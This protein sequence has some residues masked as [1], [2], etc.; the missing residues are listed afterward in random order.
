MGSV[1]RGRWR[2]G[3]WGALSPNSGM[4]SWAWLLAAV[5]L[6]LLTVSVARPPLTATK[7]EATLEPEEASN[8]YQISKPTVCSVHPGEVLKLSCPLPG[9]G[10]ITW[11]KDGSSLGNNNRTLIEQ[12]VLQI[13]DTT[14]KDSGLYA[15]TSVGKDTVCFIVNV[16]D[17]ISSGDDEDDTE[18]SEDTGADG[19][20]LSAPYWTSSA[21]MEKKL[22]AVPAANTVKFRCAAG[23]NP[24]PKLRWLKNSK[25]FRQEDRMGGYKVRSQHWTLIMESVVPSDK[26][27]YTCLVE[28]EFGSINH[29]YTL[30]VVERS[31]HRPIL[32][33]GL[34]A[35]TTVHVGEDA[36]FVCKVYSDAQP[37]IQWLKHITQNGSRY[38]IDGH[39]YVRVLKT[40]G[41]NTTDKE[42]EV[43]YLPNVTFE[44]A[45]EYTC[46]AGNSIGISYHTAWLTVLPALEK[47]PE[48]ISPDYVEIAIYCAGVFLIACMVGIVVVCRMRNTAKK[49][50][51]GG[52]PAVHKLTKQI[53]LRR[54]VTVSADSS[55]SMN[56]STPLVRI[57]TRRSSAHDEPIPEYDL[58]ED[59]RWEFS[60]DRLT[61]GKPL[62]EGC[63]GQVVMA[64]ALGIDKDKPKEAVTV[65]VKMLKDDA[66]EKDL[67]DLVSEMEMMKMIG[68]H[69]NII[70]LLGACTQ[71]GPLYVIVEYASK[72]NLREYLRARRPP[73]MEYSY[74]IARVSDEQLTFKDLVSCTYQVARGMEY[75]ASQK[76]IH[77][78]LAARNVLVTESNIMK[79]ADFG[80]ARDVHNIDYYKKTTNGRLPVKWMAPEALFDRVYTH[81]SDVWSFGVLM[82]EIF[83]LGGSP[84]PGIP[85]EELFKLLKEGHRMDKPGNCTNELYMMMKDCWHAISSQRPTFKQLV[86]DLDR[87]L[88]LSTNEEYLDLC[89]P[90]EQYS[91][92]FPDTRSSCSS[93][94]DSVFSHDPLPDEPCLP[95][96]QH[97]NGNVKT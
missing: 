77:R 91:P 96:Y 76:C 40:A 68:K 88:T 94:D 13:R 54:Q 16:T 15:C 79:I 33:A 7:G 47:T 34:P 23:G 53:P 28:N 42:I 75:L 43:L 18:R 72:G 95:K 73:G 81:Q 83:T 64:E 27:N 20:Q 48:S 46:L 39:P 69:K 38:G 93:G 49:P 52:Q 85:V 55:S 45:G 90:T 89:A 17:A 59:P 32:Q 19:E 36:R 14:P 71:D 87:I 67:S 37:H 22:H 61:L 4:A 58:P 92:S 97:I 6:S 10:T 35:N 11:T 66:T 44:D 70:N 50:D 63:F 78:D 31:P 12:E 84:Y 1:S 51:F 82:W 74:D 8:K 86:E 56:S 2:R 60:R 30:D 80:L 21:K 29:T 25:P 41:V 62:G 57:T 9:T 3:V 5:L 26:G 24:K 65:A